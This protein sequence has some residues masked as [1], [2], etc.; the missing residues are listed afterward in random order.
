MVPFGR[1]IRT[2]SAPIFG[3]VQAESQE[4]G[5]AMHKRPDCEPERLEQLPRR[6]FERRRDHVRG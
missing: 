5:S 4:I 2:V 3:S 1:V 6:V